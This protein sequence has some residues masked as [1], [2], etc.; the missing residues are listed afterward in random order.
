MELYFDNAASCRPF[1]WAVRLFA[2]TSLAAYANQEAG[3]FLGVRANRLV[4][5]A[6]NRLAEAVAPGAGVFWCNTGTDALAAVVQMHCMS[7]PGTGI[8]MTETEHPALKKAVRRF[9]AVHG[10]DVFCAKVGKEGAVDMDS[11]ASLL[12]PKVSLVA[13]HHVNAETGAIQD[14]PAVRALIDS[15]ASKSTGFLADTTQSVCKTAVPWKEAALD[16]M[17]VSGCKIGAPCGAA[18]LY[19]DPPDKGISKRLHAL[20]GHDHAVGRCVPAAA[21]VLSAAAEKNMENLNAR[22]ERIGRLRQRI[23]DSVKRSAGGKVIET[24]PAEK[25]SPYI[26]HL[27]FPEHQGAVL[28]RIL[29]SN[30]VSAA[31]GSACMAETPA[32][33]ETLTAMGYSKALAFGALRLSFWD[34]TTDEEA[35]HFKK[36]FDSAL[37]NY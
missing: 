33:S 26:L 12:T 23:L 31:A 13:L 14:L 3:G 19:R 32:A 1:E 16:Y 10:L 36:L 37:K 5:E 27:I 25:A 29:E 30:G 6:S 22:S 18:L 28:V 9:A 15:R 7:H 8:V 35:E 20:R 34:D 24:V 2:E 11:L 21:H 17:T 4:K